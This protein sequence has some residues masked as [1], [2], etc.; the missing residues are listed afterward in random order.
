MSSGSSLLSAL[1][2]PSPLLSSPA[3]LPAQRLSV[4]LGWAIRLDSTVLLSD[5][6]SLDSR[7]SLTLRSFGRF[8]GFVITRSFAGG[9]LPLPSRPRLLLSGEAF[10]LPSCPHWL[11]GPRAASRGGG[12]FGHWTL[13]QPKQ[14]QEAGDPTGGETLHGDSHMPGSQARWLLQ[15][16]VAAAA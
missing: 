12:G 6:S 1:P 4:S 16:T 8:L 11:S 10:Y 5:L 2:P 14:T 3:L 9:T 7:L 13:K 15:G